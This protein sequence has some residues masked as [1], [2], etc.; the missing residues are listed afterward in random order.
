MSVRKQ[1]ATELRARLDSKRFR[2]LDVEKMPDT[3]DRATIAVRFH[4][5]TP[6]PNSQGNLVAGFVVSLMSHHKDLEKAEDALDDDL[7]SV[8]AAFRLIDSLTWSR[9]QKATYGA[10]L[11]TGF[12]LEVTVPTNTPS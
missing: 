9:A 6:A 3:I 12:D 2:V 4:G 7:D 5:Y 8:I 10:A 11:Y 1:L